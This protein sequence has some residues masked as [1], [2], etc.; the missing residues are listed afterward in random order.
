MKEA[1]LQ[2]TKMQRYCTQQ[3]LEI[4][5][6]GA[7]P[8]ESDGEDINLQVDSDSELS[9]LSSDEESAPQPTK[10]ARLATDV[11]ETAKDG[12]VWH[13]EQVGTGPHFTL[14]SPY[15]ADG[16]PTAKAEVNQGGQSQ[17]AFRASFVSSLWTCLASFETVQFNMRS[18]LSM[19]IGSWA[20][21]N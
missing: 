8:C 1:P 6:N 16:E 21:L 10:R 2:G 9:Q 15:S 3:A 4:I 11:T 18:K 17:V 7:D 12:T 19:W 14:P 5:L 20:Y 13:E